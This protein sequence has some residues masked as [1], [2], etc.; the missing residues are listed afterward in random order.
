MD[1][2]EREMG[3]LLGGPAQGLSLY[4]GLSLLPPFPPSSESNKRPHSPPQLHRGPHRPHASHRVGRPEGPQE[5]RCVSA[6]P[7]APPAHGDSS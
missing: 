1:P 7:P 5:K 4:L 3:P 2:E 6:H